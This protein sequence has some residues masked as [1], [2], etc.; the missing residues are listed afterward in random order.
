MTPKM[1]MSLGVKPQEPHNVT[2]PQ[3]LEDFFSHKLKVPCSV[4]NIL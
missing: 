4:E 3:K 1:Q 2:N